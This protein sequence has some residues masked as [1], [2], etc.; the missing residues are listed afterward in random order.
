VRTV[1]LTDDGQRVA[2]SVLDLLSEPPS[3][4]GS[5]SAQ[6]QRQLADLLDRVAAADEKLAERRAAD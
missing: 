2:A 6:E 5:L 4:L 3:S 1:V